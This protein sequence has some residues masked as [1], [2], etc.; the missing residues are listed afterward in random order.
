[1]ALAFRPPPV[2]PALP[3]TSKTAVFGFERVI[4][5][6]LGYCVRTLPRLERI[7]LLSPRLT[8][9]RHRSSSF[10]LAVDCFGALFFCVCVCMV[11]GLCSELRKILGPARLSVRDG[12]ATE[13]ATTMTPCLVS[14]LSLGAPLF[15]WRAANATRLSEGVFCYPETLSRRGCER[16]AGRANVQRCILSYDRCRLRCAV[17][18]ILLRYC[19]LY[20]ELGAGLIRFAS[21]ARAMFFSGPEFDGLNMQVCCCSF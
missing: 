17:V 8:R 1:M 21:V 7:C 11:G 19:I 6:R 14:L 4:S 20:A 15:A 18:P 5:M 16:N 2:S 9:K 12:G 13:A 10:L 3:P